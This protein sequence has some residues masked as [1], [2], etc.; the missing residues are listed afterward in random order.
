MCLQC[1]LVK[2]LPVLIFGRAAGFNATQR[3]VPSDSSLIS[4]VYFDNPALDVYR[5]RL[6]RNEGATLIRVRAYGDI[7][8]AAT[9]EAELF[10]ERKTHH[11]SWT[12]DNSVKERCVLHPS[13]RAQAAAL[14]CAD[15]DAALPPQLPAEGQARGFAVARRAGPGGSAGE[16]ARGRRH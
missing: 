8:G 3:D 11:E 4:S 5:E 9:D 6:E 15:A 7:G 16:A 10:V 1:A 2:H 12:T 14:C 13:A